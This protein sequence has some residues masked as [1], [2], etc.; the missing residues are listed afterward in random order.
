MGEQRK[1]GTDTYDYG[2]AARRL[3]GVMDERA[4]KKRN[5]TF[6]AEVNAGAAMNSNASKPLD[7]AGEKGGSGGCVNPLRGRRFVSAANDNLPVRAAV[8]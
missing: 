8:K 7:E 2:A 1:E 3:I 4:S 5:E 6:A